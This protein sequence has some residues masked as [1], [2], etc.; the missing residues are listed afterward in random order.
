MLNGQHFKIYLYSTKDYSADSVD[1]EDKVFVPRVF[2]IGC[3]QSP[4]TNVCD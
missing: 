4:K 1:E 2:V 3:S